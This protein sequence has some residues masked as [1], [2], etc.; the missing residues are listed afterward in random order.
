[1][2]WTKAN[3]E[4]IARTMATHTKQM[5]QAGAPLRAEYSPKAA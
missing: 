4:L 5:E 1:V 3:R 2:E